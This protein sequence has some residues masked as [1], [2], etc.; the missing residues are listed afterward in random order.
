MNGLR[1]QDPWWLLLWIP[2][3]L[4]GLLAGGQCLLVGGRGLRL[5]SLDALL[6]PLIGFADPASRL[7]RALIQLI[8][9][10]DYRAFLLFNI[11]LGGAA[12]RQGHC[13]C[14]NYWK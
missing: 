13:T 1:F 2:L 11:V 7:R 10:V 4:I 9:L 12:Y 8:N 3:G 5:N 14:D 6:R